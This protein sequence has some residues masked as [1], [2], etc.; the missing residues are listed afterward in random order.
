[1]NQRQ[2]AFVSPSPSTKL[3]K[4]L[5]L[6]AQMVVPRATAGLAE[7]S[8]LADL[9]GLGRCTIEAA[10]RWPNVA[11]RR[12][13]W[14]ARQATIDPSGSSSSMRPGRQHDACRYALA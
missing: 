4:R 7:R 6:C 2:P 8:P 5:T 13:R 3:A 10:G 14:K 11:R 12:E 1:M 9:V